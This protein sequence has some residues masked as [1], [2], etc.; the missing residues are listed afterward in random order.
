MRT[1]PAG[2]LAAAPL[3]VLLPTALLPTPLLPLLVLLLAHVATAYATPFPH[4]S[5]LFLDDVLT[6]GGN[7][8]VTVRDARGRAILVGSRSSHFIASS[9]RFE[10]FSALGFGSRTGGSGGSGSGTSVTT[11]TAAAT[12]SRSTLTP[13]TRFR[14]GH[15]STRASCWSLL[16]PFWGAG[17][18]VDAYDI[19]LDATGA[20]WTLEYL[21]EGLNA[22]GHWELYPRG[23]SLDLERHIVVAP[24]DPS[25][26]SYRACYPDV[27]TPSRMTSRAVRCGA[28][29]AAAGEDDPDE[30]HL[31]L[32]PAPLPDDDD[33]DGDGDNTRYA[34]AGVAR[35]VAIVGA[36]SE[37]GEGGESEGG[38]SLLW[39]G[40]RAVA[41]GS[42]GGSAGGS[43]GSTGMRGRRWIVGLKD[44]AHGRVVVG[45]G[46]GALVSM[47]I[48]SRQ[49][50]PGGWVLGKGFFRKVWTQVRNV[51]ITRLGLDETGY[52]VHG[53]GA[54]LH[55]AASGG[56]R[57]GGAGDG[58]G[59]GEGGRHIAARGGD[60]GD[61]GG[62]AE[63]DTG[64]VWADGGDGAYHRYA[65]ATGG[66][67]A[68]LARDLDEERLGRG[69]DEMV[70]ASRVV[71]TEGKGSRGARAGGAAG[72]VASGAA[73]GGAGGG[74]ITSMFVRLTWTD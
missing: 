55:A 9:S 68:A 42:T 8:A 44:G 16:C 61:G 54:A 62:G 1:A 73:G 59:G 23:A 37:R 6:R 47:I 49:S 28:A 46:L 58:D 32:R 35:R 56:G 63:E 17:A 2:R 41:G 5:T 67:D 19:T 11:S 74:K 50:A 60:V 12:R 3:P 10:L 24:V 48:A 13:G 33:D 31:A 40:L 65:V 30:V 26:E 45:K 53:Q 22:A 57:A 27:A 52:E 21:S 70:K 7:N 43:T 15:A 18:G 20:R 51:V 66:A 38:E 34:R 14:V 29:A 64:A 4:A 71:W 39:R 69:L 72:S 36:Q 25:G